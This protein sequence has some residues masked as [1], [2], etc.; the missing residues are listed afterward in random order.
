MITDQHFNWH[1]T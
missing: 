1:V